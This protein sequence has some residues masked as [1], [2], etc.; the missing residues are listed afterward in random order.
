MNQSSAA[1]ITIND[2]VPRSLEFAL[3]ILGALMGVIVLQLS[4]TVLTVGVTLLVW[5]LMLP[6]IWRRP[7]VGLYAFLLTYPLAAL[8]TTQELITVSIPNAFLLTTSLLLLTRLKRYE[9]HPPLIRRILVLV[10]IFLVVS[11]AVVLMAPEPAVALRGMSTRI[12]YCLTVL[13]LVVLLRDW[14]KIRVALKCMV[15]SA[16]LASI[17]TILLIF[18]PDLLP[19]PLQ[20]VGQIEPL[21]RVLPGVRPTGLFVS[22]HSFASWVVYALAITSMSL[23]SPRLFGVRRRW[24]VLSMMLMGCGLLVNQTRIAWLAVL[25]LSALA[26]CFAP[27][28]VSGRRRQSLLLLAAFGLFGTWFALNSNSVKTTAEN[29]VWGGERELS[30]AE[31]VVQYQIAFN[32]LREHPWFGIG[33]AGASFYLESAGLHPN[34]HNIFLEELVAFGIVGFV[35]Y[36]AFLPLAL[37]GPL[38]LLLSN[39]RDHSLVGASILIA[40]ISVMVVYQV[41]SGVGEKGY[42]ITIGLG[43]AASRLLGAGDKPCKEPKKT[44]HAAIP[45]AN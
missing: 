34:I 40:S 22:V 17:A 45:L 27:L 37:A 42:W 6:S 33:P 18:M 12:G 5:I 32:L 9:P 41:Y 11:L 4:T 44:D 43:A 10:P 28:Y 30:S 39:R 21:L 29:F 19:K 31:R 3:G 1:N 35:P 24:A 7:Q 38:K 16:T 15:V 2:I 25:V 8:F 23:F 36:I 14:E 26:I 13:V 20:N